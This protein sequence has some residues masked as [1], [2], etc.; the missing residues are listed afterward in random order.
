M[1]QASVAFLH[2]SLS[3][4]LIPAYVLHLTISSF[5]ETLENSTLDELLT[6]CT[7]CNRSHIDRQDLR[8]SSHPRPH[9]RLQQIAKTLSSALC[10]MYKIN[11]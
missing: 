4:L 3:E 10:K 11:R 1:Q 2:S 5:R 8:G 7:D 9:R 6:P